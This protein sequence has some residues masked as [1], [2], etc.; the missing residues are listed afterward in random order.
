MT[1]FEK[2]LLSL[3]GNSVIMDNSGKVEIRVSG[4]VGNEP[5]SPENFDIREIKELFDVV[6]TLLYPT[7]KAVRAPISFSMEEGSVR[8]IFRTTVQSAA[9]FLTIVALVQQSNSLD[10][11]ELPAARALQEVQKSAIRTGFT[12][13]FSAPDK[14][15]PALTISKDTSFHINDNLWAD[16]EFYFYGMLINAGGK[17]KT[18]IHL[19]TKDNGVIILATEREYLQDQKDNVLYKQFMVRTTGKQNISSG[20]IDM[21]SLQLLE[22]TPYDPTYQEQYLAKLIKRASPKWAD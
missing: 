14:E 12:Y 9:T 4:R 3:Q 1:L 8:N 13:E 11:L 2:L 15:I 7:A 19:Q 5:L 10:V 18:N 20:A 22:M 6:E 21:S 16:A 17:D